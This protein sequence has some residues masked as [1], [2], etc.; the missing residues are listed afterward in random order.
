MQMKERDSKKAFKVFKSHVEKVMNVSGY[1]PRFD[2]A[3][4]YTVRIPFRLFKE[5]LIQ[6]L[7]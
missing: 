7:N 2:D 3:F 5:K 6:S 1:A 4:E